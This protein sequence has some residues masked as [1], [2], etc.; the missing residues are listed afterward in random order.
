MKYDR[1]PSRPGGKRWRFV[2]VRSRGQVLGRCQGV[3]PRLHPHG[4]GEGGPTNHSLPFRFLSRLKE[5]D[6]GEVNTQLWAA[7]R[8]RPSHHSSRLEGLSVITKPN[9]EAMHPRV[10][11]L[12]TRRRH[13]G[14]QGSGGGGGEG[15]GGD[16]TCGTMRFQTRFRAASTNRKQA[17]LS[18]RAVSASISGF[19]G[20]QLFIYSFTSVTRPRCSTGSAEKE[21][22]EEEGKEG[23]NVGRPENTSDAQT[24][25]QASAFMT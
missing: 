16:A 1:W 23:G 3:R 18:R 19:G 13:R 4:G 21:S 2:S 11:C 25:V 6:L 14:G 10:R 20:Q 9:N 17:W 5:D 7:F 12:Q 15:E 24:C 8:S 22:K